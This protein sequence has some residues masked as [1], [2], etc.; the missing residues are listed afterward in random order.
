MS[1]RARAGFTLLE[2][3]LAML[4]LGMVVAMVS[5]SLS[6]SIK[7]I[8]GTLDQGDVY[9]RAQVA[10]ER[11]SEDLTSALLPEDAD[12][13][14]DQEAGSSGQNSVLSFA[15]MTHLVFDSKNGQPGLGLISYAVQPDKDNPK[16]LLL[17]RADSLHRPTDGEKKSGQEVEAFLLADRLRSVKF[18]FRD[19]NGEEQESWDT[20]ATEEDPT[21]KR[22]LPAAVSCRLE[23]WLDDEQETSISFQT[24]VLLPVGLIRPAE[25][26]DA[27]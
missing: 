13:I 9:Y 12:F 5:V 24:T 21:K 22:R 19:Q 27:A 4:V 10:F 17:L 16:H 6:G 14:S 23:F 26:D 20:T 25:Q 2:I 3:M 7:I 8:E 18:T 15:S 1:Y 11:I